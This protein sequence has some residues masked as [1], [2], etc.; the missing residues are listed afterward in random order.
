VT[1]RSHTDQPRASGEPNAV[2]SHAASAET[3]SVLDTVAVPIVV[4]D[5]D[6]RLVRF[7]RAATEVF[8]F[9]ASDVGQRLA[10]I[11][12]LSDVKDI[13]NLCG[14]AMADEV[15]CR[16]DVR[17]GDRRFLLQLAPYWTSPGRIAGAVLTFTN[18]TAFRASLEQAI[19]E[20]E[21]TK[22]ILNAVATPLVVL[23]GDLRV[24][25]GNRAFYTMFGV[26]REKAQGVPLREL[27]K[28]DWRESPLWPALVAMVP[29]NRDFEPLEVQRDFP[30]RGTRTVQ[31]DARWLSRDGAA[32]IVLAIQDV[33]E[34]KRIEATLQD[35]DRRK[36]E[37]LALLAHELRNPLAPLRTGLELVRVSGDTPD[38]VRR[39]R[40]MMERQVNQMVRLIDDLLDVSR[41]TSGKIVLQPVPTTLTDLIQRAVEAQRYAIEAAKVELTVI[42]PSTR[43]V[44]DVDPA[45]FVQVLSNILHNA[46][47][48]T[49]PGGKIV[50]AADVRLD[51]DP[52]EVTI[53]VSDTGV[54][55]SRDTLPRIFDLFTQGES[56]TARAHGGLGIGLA[57]ARRLIEMHNGRISARSEGPGKGSVFTIRLPIS[58]ATA[59]PS[60]ASGPISRIASRVVIIDDNDDAAYAMAMLIEELGGG[61]RVA[62]DA[63][64][65]LEAVEQF[66]PD[67]VFLDIGMP[68][69]DGYEAC[70]Q[71]RRLPSEKRVLIVAVTG[72]GQ[73]QDKQRAL[74]AGFDAHLT[75]PVDPALLTRVL[76]QG[77]G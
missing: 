41:I 8:P 34:H 4:I 38:A 64:S 37:F 30:G 9:S 46:S 67:V 15:A 18:V 12:A 43:C 72:W 2:D 10:A 35:A 32:T 36:D 74:E 66:Q 13:E 40:S 23:D 49:S 62:H 57:L 33:T 42:S 5:H 22:A 45:R 61:A 58:G 54:G 16:R 14:Q 3:V 44:V 68:D 50:C 59:H 71:L 25:S 65:G 73:P 47:K 29:N 1:T 28:D 27:G 55:I 69:I 70:R 76:G 75:K 63:K 48:F 60:L 39:V 31:V 19:Y 24:Q 56:A 20:R 6:C 21:Y 52:P 7:N 51:K 53:T 77:T 17:S 11:T 26:A